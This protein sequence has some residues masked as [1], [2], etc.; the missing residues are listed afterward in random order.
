MVNY[1]FS[2]NA[3]LHKQMREHPEIKWSE[4][5]RQSIIEYLAKLKRGSA[6]TTQEL[7][8]RLKIDLSNIDVEKEIALTREGRRLSEEHARE[9]LK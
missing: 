3:E 7:R 4:V 2:I 9:L 8:K 1:T 5:L 6:I